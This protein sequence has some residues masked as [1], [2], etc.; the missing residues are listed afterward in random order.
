[1]KELD[2]LQP[3]ILDDDSVVS[4]SGSGRYPARQS[5]VIRRGKDYGDEELVD[6]YLKV[7]GDL[8]DERSFH[9][10]AADLGCGHGEL[11]EAL[12]SPYYHMRAKR[13]MGNVRNVMAGRLEKALYQ[14]AEKSPDKAAL[15]KVALTVLGIYFDKQVQLSLHADVTYSD[16]GE[17]LPRS[18]RE[19]QL[20]LAQILS[21]TGFSV[22]EYRQVVEGGLD[23]IVN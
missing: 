11:S 2:L 23:G 12:S 17:E 10:I 19:K 18:P 13:A 3:I 5:G 9:E 7:L 15:M 1:M 16:A 22:E 21:D 20:Y 14:A 4:D 6:E 8:A